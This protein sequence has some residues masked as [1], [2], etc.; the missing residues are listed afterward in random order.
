MKTTF[1]KMNAINLDE[2]ISFVKPAVQSL[3]M[4]AAT[5]VLHRMGV[6]SSMIFLITSAAVKKM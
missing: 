4:G 5:V 1:K 2:L 3:S 6:P